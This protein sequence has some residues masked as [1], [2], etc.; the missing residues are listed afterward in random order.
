MIVQH[1]TRG[2]ILW[3]T[4]WSV[5][6]TVFDRLRVLLPEFDHLSI[7]YSDADSPEKMLLQT[8]T[9]ARNFLYSDGPTCKTRAFRGP[10][11]IGGW[12]LGALLAL[13]LAVG[14]IADGLVLF[15]ATARFTRSKEEMDCGW[16]DAY[17]RQMIAG[18]TKDRLAVET[19]FRQLM[20]TGAEWEAGLCK[21]LPAIGR[22]TTPALIAGLQ[23]LRR[24]AISSQLAEI[25]CPVLLVHGTEDKIC[26]FGAALE[27]Q[28]Q[29]PLAQL[30]AIPVC[31]HSPFLGREAYIAEE[32]RR[33]WHGQQNKCYSASI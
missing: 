19:K 9:A 3:L 30:L 18:I 1:E 33:W 27:L 2:T 22:W 7:D 28:A 11:L 23:I 5:P 29:L 14:G 6:D 8:E 32:L 15:A 16:A 26:P 20:F 21:N 17:V 12:S 25:D 4:G 10:L 13:R 24:E 31:G